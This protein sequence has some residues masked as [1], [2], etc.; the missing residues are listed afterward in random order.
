MVGVM[1]LMTIMLAHIFTHEKLTSLEVLGFI[2]GFIG[3]IILF[4]PDDFSLSLISDWK[5]QL[6]I[7]AAAFCYAVTTV[8]AKRAPETH[9]AVGGAMMLIWAA[10]AGVIAA[11][12]SGLPDSPP[13]MMGHL[14]AWGLGIGSTGI[15]TILYLYVI[16]KTGPGMMARINYFVPVASV[17]LGVGLLGEEFKWR[18]VISFGVIV[19]GVIIS[20]MGKRGKA[21]ARD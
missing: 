19:L 10:I 11:I 8:G 5:S 18:M 7:V 17:I 12:I 4:L 14:M 20:R 15:A 6:L 1:P 16:Q 13:A 3:I 9:S 21:Q 2:V